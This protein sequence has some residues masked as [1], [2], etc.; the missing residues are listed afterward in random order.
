LRDLEPSHDGPTSLVTGVTAELQLQMLR[1]SSRTASTGMFL[2]GGGAAR[3]G[4]HAE[5]PAKEGL[6]AQNGREMA[7]FE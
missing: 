6:D 1:V 4:L 5:R 2:G 3:V 7:F